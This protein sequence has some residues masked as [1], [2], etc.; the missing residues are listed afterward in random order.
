[1]TIEDTEGVKSILLEDNEKIIISTPGSFRNIT[2]INNDDLLNIVGSSDII[3]CIKGRGLL[4]KVYI[5]PVVPRE[6]ILEKCDEW[7]A[8]FDR[9]LKYFSGFVE[10]EKSLAEKIQLLVYF[11][12]YSPLDTGNS[13][14]TIKISLAS[15]YGVILEGVSI[16]VDNQNENI[17]KYLVAEVI[18]RFLSL[19]CQ[20]QKFKIDANWDGNIRSNK[21]NRSS[22][23]HS[24]LSASLTQKTDYYAI[25]AAILKCHNLDLPFEQ[26]ID[27]LRC[28]VSS[29]PMVSNSLE[30]SIVRSRRQCSHIFKN[31]VDKHPTLKPIPADGK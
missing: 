29:Q 3:G 10:E 30:E 16:E 4:D 23:I 18:S 26:I 7:L 31:E 19:N 8:M 22:S 21:C 14:Q 28:A 5:P 13:G 17:Y 25:I 27:N 15:K 6:E 2:V 12:E 20:G 11:G 24:L 9:V 1:M